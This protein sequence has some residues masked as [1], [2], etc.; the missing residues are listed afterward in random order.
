MIVLL[1]VLFAPLES[2]AFKN[3]SGKS[4]IVAP[5]C[6]SG[7]CFIEFMRDLQ[8]SVKR[9]WKPKSKPKKKAVVYFRAYKNGTISDLRLKEASGSKIYD[10]RALAAIRAVVIPEFPIDAPSDV[11][12]WF[13]FEYKKRS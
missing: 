1:L 10:E 4:E 5:H 6:C 13:T 12:I 9:N 3:K 7:P 2:Q 8:R 11:E